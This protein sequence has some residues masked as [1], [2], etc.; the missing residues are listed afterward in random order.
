V[1]TSTEAANLSAVIQAAGGPTSSAGTALI[2][3]L[4]PGDGAWLQG[5]A[6]YAGS[7]DTNGSAPPPIDDGPTY[8]TQ[9][10]D[11]TGAEAA[12]VKCVIHSTKPLVVGNEEDWVFDVTAQYSITCPGYTRG[13]PQQI[14]INGFLE[15]DFYKLP[16]YFKSV[17][18][19]SCYDQRS[20]TLTGH[21]VIE[22][23]VN[24]STLF[25]SLFTGTHAWHVH[26][27]VSGY[28]VNQ[29]GTTVPLGGYES[30]SS[31]GTQGCGF[32]LVP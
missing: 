6:E 13:A 9:P 4:S 5:H 20:C 23:A 22:N 25:S 3:G 7:I 17:G 31:A 28:Y 27:S 16:G 10:D 11:D 26:S 19:K 1:N 30:P 21:D 32:D 18:S 8:S 12:A 15:G 29:N 2:N 24:C 14:R